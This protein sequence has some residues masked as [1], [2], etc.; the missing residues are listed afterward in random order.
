MIRFHWDQVQILADFGNMCLVGTHFS[1]L[2]KIFLMDLTSTF[3][4]VRVG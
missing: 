1:E 3:N 2:K 4:L